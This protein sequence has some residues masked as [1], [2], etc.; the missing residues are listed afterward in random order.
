[1]TDQQTPPPPASASPRDAK[2]QAKAD[3]AYRKASRP[4]F[5]KKR[6][7]VPLALLLVIIMSQLAGGGGDKAA[8]PGTATDTSQSKVEDSPKA[9]KAAPKPAAVAAG[10]GSKVLDGKYE[11]VVTGV[12]RPGK[13]IAGEFGTELTAQGEF[14][15][16]RVNITNVGDEAQMLDSS[17]QVLFN[18]KGQKS[19][20][21][22]A[23]MSLKDA[24]KFFLTNINP[25]NTVKGAPLLFDVAPGTK[26]A[27]VELHDSPFSDGVKVKVS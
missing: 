15:L 4:W 22:S 13:S 25:G 10:I 6:V 26:I 8:T 1:M 2:A 14:V 5:K 27:S 18:D 9:V 11:F 3:K 7:I 21:S 12:E 23:L 19:S 20:P 16:V 24:N 17:S